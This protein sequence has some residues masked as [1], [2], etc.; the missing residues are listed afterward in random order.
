MHFVNHNKKSV[1]GQGDVS[2]VFGGE[3]IDALSVM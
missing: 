1:S 3:H 2:H